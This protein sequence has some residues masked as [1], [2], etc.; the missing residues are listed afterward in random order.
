MVLP[1]YKELPLV[2]GGI[3]KRGEGLVEESIIFYII[4]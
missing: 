2:G 4:G 1:K 3:K